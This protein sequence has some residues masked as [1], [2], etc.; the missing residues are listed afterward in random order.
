[1]MPPSCPISGDLVDAVPVPGEES[2]SWRRRLGRLFR[3]DPDSRWGSTFLRIASDLLIVCDE[4]LNICHH[5]RAFLKAAGYQQGSFGGQCLLTFFPR[6]ERDT[7]I[8]V[9]NDWRR[10]HAAGMRFRAPLL[11]SRGLRL[12]EMRVVRCRDPKGVYFYYLVG[13]DAP[14]GRESG[15]GHQG[16]E[17]EAFFQ[18]LPVAAWRTDAALRITRVYGNLWPELG[19]ASEDLVG[20]VFGKRHDTLLP[21]ILR[22]IDCS[23]SLAGMSLQTEVEGESGRFCVTVEPFLDGDGRVVGTVGLMRRSRGGRVIL[24]ESPLPSGER[25]RHHRPPAGVGGMLDIHTG[26]VP[27][28]SES[29]ETLG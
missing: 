26:R 13:R 17:D 15:A 20:E 16:Q 6:R 19:A 23:D 18:G 14:V 4:S 7:I 25:A 21:G 22:G 1:M 11:T 9:F 27:R 29:E 28:Y 5:N 2:S 3:S 10:G 12:F 8:G 24:P